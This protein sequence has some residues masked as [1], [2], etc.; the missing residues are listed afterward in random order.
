MAVARHLQR[1]TRGQAGRPCVLLFGL[2]PRGVCPADRSPGRWWALTPPFHPYPDISEIGAVCFCGTFRRVA[3][4]GRYPARCPVELG[5]SSPWCFAHQSAITRP[6]GPTSLYSENGSPA[7]LGARLIQGLI[8]QL[9][10]QGI[11]STRDGDSLKGSEAPAQV[12]HAGEQ[13]LQARVAH[14]VAAV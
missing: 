3:P 10:G 5:L 11:V 2:A 6:T 4:P 12:F 13:A 9:V 14:P 8:G 7:K 1:P